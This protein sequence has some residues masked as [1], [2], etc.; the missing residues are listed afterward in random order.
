MEKHFT[1][2]GECG[3]V[4]EMEKVCENETCSMKG[5]MMAECNCEDGMHGKEKEETNINVN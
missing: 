4:A 1:C 2:K 5:Q 3:A